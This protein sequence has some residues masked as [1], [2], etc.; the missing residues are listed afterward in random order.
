MSSSIR[1]GVE[2][3]GRKPESQ[4]GR[5]GKEPW[6]NEAARREGVE[7]EGGISNEL[8]RGGDVEAVWRRN[9][10]CRRRTSDHHR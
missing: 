8:R 10:R 2:T 9:R 4:S 7:G 1:I 5:G 6:V 3:A